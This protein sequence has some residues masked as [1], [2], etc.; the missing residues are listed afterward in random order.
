MALK[1]G[2]QEV[3][4]K[5][6]GGE[7]NHQIGKGEILG[8]N[9]VTWA[10]YLTGEAMKDVNHMVKLRGQRAQTHTRAH[11]QGLCKGANERRA[12]SQLYEPMSVKSGFL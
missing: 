12:K 9:K 10:D 6:I 3:L 8:L 5:L 2:F 11:T 4:F 1:W 7:K